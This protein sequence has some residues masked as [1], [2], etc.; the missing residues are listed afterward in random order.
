MLCEEQ[1]RKCETALAHIADARRVMSEPY[2]PMHRWPIDMI[3][4]NTAILRDIIRV[5]GLKVI[6]W[7]IE[8]ND[9]NLPDAQKY[10]M[11]RAYIQEM[12]DQA[13][14]VENRKRIEAARAEEERVYRESPE[15][16]LKQKQLKLENDQALLREEK[17]KMNR[18]R[19]LMQQ[20]IEKIGQLETEILLGSSN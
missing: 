4:R 8:V 2:A 7:G 5:D 16:K 17:E 13:L 14:R 11:L 12:S 6:M 10:P 18:Y 9:E 1:Q 19:L 3:D 20:S 15:Y